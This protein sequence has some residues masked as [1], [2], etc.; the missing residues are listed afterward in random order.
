MKPPAGTTDPYGAKGA[1]IKLKAEGGGGGGL[2]SYSV[3][4]FLSPTIRSGA[5]VDAT[6]LAPKI[7][8][9][10]AVLAV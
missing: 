4:Y 8:I 2:R 6:T 9:V 10:G 3:S 1:P 5:L 7:C